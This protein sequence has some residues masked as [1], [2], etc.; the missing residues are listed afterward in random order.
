MVSPNSGAAAPTSGGQ[1]GTS[2]SGSTGLLQKSEFGN[3]VFI[4]RTTRSHADLKSS[5]DQKCT[6]FECTLKQIG[7]DS[8]KL[9]VV[10]KQGGVLIEKSSRRAVEEAFSGTDVRV[11]DNRLSA[12]MLR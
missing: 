9:E 11:F 3:N 6:G 5:L 8:F 2:T 4:L 10:P 1:S 7:K 12:P